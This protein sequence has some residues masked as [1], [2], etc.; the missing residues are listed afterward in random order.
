MTCLFSFV[1]STLCSFSP[2]KITIKHCVTCFPNA[3]RKTE[4]KKDEQKPKGGK[5]LKNWLLITDKFE[6][7]LWIT[8]ISFESMLLN[9]QHLTQSSDNIVHFIH[10]SPYPPDAVYDIMGE[11][12]GPS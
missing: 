7:I 4:R 5:N 1:P 9:G 8:W 6:K 12:E 2:I 3:Q 11:E 10:S